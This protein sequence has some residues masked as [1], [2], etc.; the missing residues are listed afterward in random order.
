[1][2]IKITLG[3]MVFL[4]IFSLLSDTIYTYVAIHY[5]VKIEVFGYTISI[6]YTA[7]Q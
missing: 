1:M 4:L 5:S 6:I 3:G 2:A 7:H